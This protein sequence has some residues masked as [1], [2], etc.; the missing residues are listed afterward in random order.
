LF[1]GLLPEAAENMYLHASL[2]NALDLRLRAVEIVAIG[3][4]ADEFA[5]AALRLAFLDRVVARAVS[6]AD[7]PANHPARAANLAPAGTAAFVCAGDTCSLPVIAAGE[8][9]AAVAAA[10]RWGSA[11]PP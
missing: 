4:R 10:R 8:L 5:S 11:A 3:P 1:D 2:I 6:A 7:L 9:A